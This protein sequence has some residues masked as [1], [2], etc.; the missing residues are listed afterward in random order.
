MSNC[1]LYETLSE[2]KA[3]QQSMAW[4]RFSKRKENV[5]E[6]S[7]LL[8][9]LIDFC[10]R[11]SRHSKSI[12][13]EFESEEEYVK[14]KHLLWFQIH[15]FAYCRS[16]NL[17]SEPDY[18]IFAQMSSHIGSANIWTISLIVIRASYLYIICKVARDSH[19]ENDENF[20]F[21]WHNLLR[22]ICRCK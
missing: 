6:K 5:R 12:Q 18:V 11:V 9:L 15:S 1:T 13:T 22:R 14:P 10:W 16:S 8:R 20:Y 2:F 17:C 7:S 3:K 19:G 4:N 21:C